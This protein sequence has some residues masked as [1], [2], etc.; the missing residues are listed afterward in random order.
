M[1]L[2]IDI[3]RHTIFGPYYRKGFELGMALGFERGAKRV[4]KL[5]LRMLTSR[6]GP[7]PRD[8]QT[9]LRAMNPEQISDLSLRIYEV[10][11]LDELLPPTKPR[12]N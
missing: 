4:Q 7:V 9:Q 10:S 3:K 2:L 6:F 1:S 11:T 8:R 12:K 5:V